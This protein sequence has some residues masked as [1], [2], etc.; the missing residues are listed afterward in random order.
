MSEVEQFDRLLDGL[1]IALEGLARSSHK[2]EEDS[3]IR[4]EFDEV[5]D[6]VNMLKLY[7]GRSEMNPSY[8]F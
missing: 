7:L 2:I 5:V 6:K 1:D 3:I 8:Y 4:E